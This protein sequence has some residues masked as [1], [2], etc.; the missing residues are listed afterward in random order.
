[1]PS[2]DL[3]PLF[4]PLRLAGTELPNR[5]MT[6]A[7][8]LQYGEG[9]L[10]SDRHLAIYEE[11]ARGGVGLMFSEQLTASPLS[12]SPFAS[13]IRAYDERQVERFAA[14][15]Q[16]LEPYDSRF[17]A[18][19]FSGGVS[20]S[21]S[22]GLSGWGP[23]R[24]PSRIGEPG[25]EEPLPLSA[26]ELA[27]IAADYARSA[28]HVKAGGL[29]GVEIHG[30]HGWLVGQFLSPFYN[31]RQDEYGGSVENRC[32]FALEVGAAMR[33]EVG[34]AFPL[35]IALT[36][37]EMIGDD[38]ITPDDTLAQ[39]E[40]LLAAGTFDFF[41][42]SIGSPHSVHFTIAPMAVEEGFAL[43]FAARAR[44]LCAGRA[45]V[46]VAGRVVNPRMA[47]A[48]VRDGAA[49]MVAMSRAQLADPHLTR[50][51]R[52][53]RPELIRRCIGANVCVGRAKEGE[54]VACVLTP[55]TG[56]ELEGWP[57]G[58]LPRVA[59]GEVRRVLVAGAG[60]A[61]LRA[62]AIAAARGHEVT[63][64]ER[65]ERAG[66]HLA[67]IS[68][69]PTRE[70]WGRAVEDL[71]AELARSGA[72]L[73]VG[74]AVDR[75]LVAREAPDLVLLAAG[76]EWEGGGES[77]ATPNGIAVRGDA[78]VLGLD[79]ALELARSSPDSLGTSVV[80]ADDTGSYAPLGLAEALA[81]AGATVRFLTARGTIGSEPDFHLELPH[82]MPRLRALGVEL[83]TDRVVRAVD[84][85]EL[86]VA[87]LWGGDLHIYGVD[88]LVLALRRRPR[89]ALAAELAG[90]GPEVVTIGD[91]LAPR[92]TAAAIEEAERV[93]L[94]I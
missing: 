20:G 88:T 19:L 2:A 73:R 65:R 28:A 90:S 25:G 11:R 67:D 54:P 93:A 89:A 22:A 45:A 14:L 37:D 1:V 80:I 77:A 9:G 5:V 31:R 76:S 58:D 61:G 56:R 81:A 12:R 63:V 36:Y 86:E 53:G 83:A 26:E 41:D 71:L 24:G 92:S 55:A 7:M 13:E 59:N 21:S 33:A 15:A 4:Q 16:R 30:A 29:D 87:D 10:I 69:L 74:T 51:A 46:F 23:V 43:G 62:G 32:R 75:E 39:L 48:A 66:G 40:V 64:C 3:S 27:V 38:G 85:G 91:A 94:A 18:Q 49:D 34:P 72:A 50:K 68:W 82:L 35:G 57:H 17:F 60:P 78:R 42:F 70:G 47:A 52:E 8:T 6:S 44:E 79:A 84:G